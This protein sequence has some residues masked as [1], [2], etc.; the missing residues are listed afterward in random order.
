MLPMIYAFGEP[1]G[2]GTVALYLLWLEAIQ[3]RCQVAHGT[4]GSGI[5]L[6]MKLFV[7][8]GFVDGTGKRGTLNRCASCKTA[9]MMRT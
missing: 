8:N 1:W 3:D 6:L 7:N 5:A 4:V 2:G 9:H